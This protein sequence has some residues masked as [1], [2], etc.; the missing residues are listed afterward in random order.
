MDVTSTPI[1]PCEQI[2][3]NIK[4][5]N[6]T[7]NNSNVAK[8]DADI[9]KPTTSMVTTNIAHIKVLKE[10]AHLQLFTMS[11]QNLDLDVQEY[12]FLCQKG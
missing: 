1:Q 4:A 12:I 10:F 3:G 7:I 9:G 11:L 8:L 5:K 2:V 6:M